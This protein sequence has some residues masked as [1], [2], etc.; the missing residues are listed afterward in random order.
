MTVLLD[1]DT[2]ATKNLNTQ[3]INLQLEVKAT[4]LHITWDSRITAEATM[5]ILKPSKRLL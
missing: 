1:F 2:E 4:R 3:N 5:I